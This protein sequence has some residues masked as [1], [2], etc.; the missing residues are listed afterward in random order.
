MIPR[1]KEQFNN[2]LKTKIMSDLNLK[3]VNEIP[4]LEKIIINIGDGKACD[5]RKGCII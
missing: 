3:N 5:G 1:L 2:E 4:N